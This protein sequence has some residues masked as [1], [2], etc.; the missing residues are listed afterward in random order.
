MRAAS[1]ALTGENEDEAT[2]AF[3]TA[4]LPSESPDSDA[5]K[6]VVSSAVGDSG[7]DCEITFAS[8]CVR[9]ALFRDLDASLMPVACASVLA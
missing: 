8:A 4:A 3:E 6:E 2:G 5:S 9:L 1:T 7:G